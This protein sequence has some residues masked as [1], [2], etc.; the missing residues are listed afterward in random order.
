MPRYVFELK[1]TEDSEA[2]AY[3]VVFP[4]L[5][6]AWREAQSAASDWVTY[7]EK[8]GVPIE[9]HQQFNIYD[10]GAEL[11]AIVPFFPNSTLH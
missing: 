9:L 2:T 7:A 5:P 10:E 4:D 1:G 3:Q 11:V 6:A 8:N